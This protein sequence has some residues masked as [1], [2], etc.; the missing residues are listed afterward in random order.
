MTV[1]DESS[2]TTTHHVPSYRSPIRESIWLYY[3]SSVIG[4]YDYHSILPTPGFLKPKPKAR[5][6]G[7]ARERANGY[8]TNHPCDEI[9]ESPPRRQDW[10]TGGRVKLGEEYYANDGIV[11]LFSQWHPGECSPSRCLHHSSHTNPNP[12]P[13]FFGSSSPR[14]M[15]PGIWNVCHI[16]DST[17]F[18]V[19]PLWWGT[20]LQEEFWAELGEWLERVDASRAV[21]YYPRATFV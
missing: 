10:G 9:L 18:S 8:G 3:I 7:Y 12:S 17:H 5:T 16:P 1:K 4:S 15:R 13:V 11:P 21:R 2:K 6:N 19:M 14:P 20:R